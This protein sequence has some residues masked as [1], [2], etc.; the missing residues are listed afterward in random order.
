MST[1]CRRILSIP[2]SFSL[3]ET[4]KNGR[5]Y[6]LSL[7][8]TF[9]LLTLPSSRPSFSGKDSNQ[10][11]YVASQDFNDKDPNPT[12]NS[13]DD[14]SAFLPHLSF[15]PPFDTVGDDGKRLVGPGWSTN[16]E[17]LVQQSFAR[18]TPDRQSKRG[19]LWSTKAIGAREKFSATMKFRIHGQGK[20]FYG[21]GLA[22]WFIQR[23]YNIEGKLHGIDPD[24]IGFGVIIDTFRNAEHGNSHKDV[25]IV[26][27]NGTRSLDA[28]T[29]YTAATT[30]TSPGSVEENIEGN[31]YNNR[32][33]CDAKVRYH[34]ERADF[35]VTNSS[36]VKVI[37]EDDPIP[38]ITV[39]VDQKGDGKWTTPSC[40]EMT[41]PALAPFK[42]WISQAHIGISASTGQLADNHDVISLHTYSDT[43]FH[44][45]A[46]EV[47]IKPKFEPGQDL[48]IEARIG[49]IEEAISTVFAALE[50]IQHSH[51]YTEIA[52]QDHITNALKKLQLQESKLETR[53]SAVETEIKDEI[54]GS[55]E[56]RLKTLER[57]MDSQLVRKVANMEQ[58]ISDRV[59]RKVKKSQAKETTMDKKN[60]VIDF[61]SDEEL[62]LRLQKI[63]AKCNSAGGWRLYMFFIVL[64]YAGGCV[65]AYK[66]LKKSH[67]L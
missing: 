3:I 46:D 10:F 52:F 29:K 31:S 47:I 45:E 62:E 28:I 14:T 30:T 6:I 57:T 61:M 13:E 9:L 35:T 15:Q 21:D 48:P 60:G 40:I 19:S 11:F 8:L 49:R 38:T 64:L 65:V 24:F 16:G 59:A 12:K 26:W 53:M 33:G 63:E 17:T 36:K 37:Y 32:Y 51:E 4:P 20:K 39:H 41:I 58:N 43:N 50:H 34:N 2:S 1:I 54:E 5:N 27:N 67:I 7:F 44:A 23:P 56:N 18:L 25:S 22:L 55:M 42:G 66:K